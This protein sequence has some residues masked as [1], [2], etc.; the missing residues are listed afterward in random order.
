[1]LLK[2]DFS[3]VSVRNVGLPDS[4]SWVWVPV[5]GRVD[6]VHHPIVDFRGILRPYRKRAVTSM[7]DAVISR[8]II[9]LS[10]IVEIES[11]VRSIW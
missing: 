9:G 4:A 6:L 1:M 3:R 7:P 10:S 2:P 8:C 11:S 5:D